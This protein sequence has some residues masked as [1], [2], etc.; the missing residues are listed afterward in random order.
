VLVR[1]VVLRPVLVRYV[2]LR[3]VLVRLMII[4][5]TVLRERV[6]REWGRMK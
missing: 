1:N 4:I 3:P 5:F 6:R 2:V